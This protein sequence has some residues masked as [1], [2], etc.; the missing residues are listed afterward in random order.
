MIRILVYCVLLGGVSQAARAAE[1]MDTFQ[2]KAVRDCLS[3]L[4]ELAIIEDQ[5]PYYLRGDFDGDRQPDVVV[6][7]QSTKGKNGAVL[8]GSKIGR[9]SIGPI[10]TSSSASQ[11]PDD[12]FAPMWGVATRKDLARMRKDTEQDIPTP[13]GEAILMVW[14][15]AT[16]IL[17]WNG[18]RVKWFQIEGDDTE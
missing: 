17:F 18:K 10:G 3:P 4:A 7:V 11:V 15:D 8:C 16:G 6:A 1:A 2:P 12:V 13:V 14:E 9:I 5:N